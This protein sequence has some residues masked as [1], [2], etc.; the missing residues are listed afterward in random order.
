MNSDKRML[1]RNL[2]SE[3]MWK[4]IKNVQ[5]FTEMMHK[6][7]SLRILPNQKCNLNSPIWLQAQLGGCYSIR[8]SVEIIFR[9]TRLIPWKNILHVVY[10][11]KIKTFFISCNSVN[12]IFQISVTEVHILCRVFEERFKISIC[13]L[14]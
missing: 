6:V 9:R 1:F 10:H 12:P 2:I 14:I 13:S 5:Y 7:L 11:R 3:G 8:S 4:K